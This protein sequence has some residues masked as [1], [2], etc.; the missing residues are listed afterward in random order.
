[1]IWA[2]KMALA[3]LELPGMDVVGG[4]GSA[5]AADFSC[6][7]FG[8]FMQLR[9]RIYLKHMRKSPSSSMHCDAD[10]GLLNLYMMYMHLFFLLLCALKCRF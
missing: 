6:G 2:T 8:E 7:K 9:F 5:Q 4:V 1:M 10:F 3:W